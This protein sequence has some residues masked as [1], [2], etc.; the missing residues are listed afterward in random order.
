M[1]DFDYISFVRRKW[2]MHIQSKRKIKLLN[3]RETMDGITGS[4]IS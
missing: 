1:D 3:V 2:L 4:T